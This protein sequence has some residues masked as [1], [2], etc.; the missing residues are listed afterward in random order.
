MVSIVIADT[1]NGITVSAAGHADYAPRGQ[2]IVCAGISAVLYGCLS[3]LL[4]RAD[5]QRGASEE[6]PHVF[7][8]DKP[9]MLVFSTS[10]FSDRFDL[11]AARIIAGSLRLLAGEYPHHVS[12]R[13]VNIG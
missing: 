6:P 5:A 7:I 2:D 4:E 8:S 9:E 1:G 3:C 12:V 10:G 13:T 11:D